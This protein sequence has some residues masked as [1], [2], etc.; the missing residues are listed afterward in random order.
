M[1]P[2]ELV[3]N[4]ASLPQGDSRALA[5]SSTAI[6]LSIGSAFFNTDTYD[7]PSDVRRRDTGWQTVYAAVRMAVEALKES[8]DMLLPLKAV[9]GAMSVLMKN[10]DVGVSCP[11]TEHLIF[12]RFS[13]QQTLD[14]MNIMEEIEQRVHSLSGVLASPVGEDDYAEKGRRVELRRFVL[15]CTNTHCMDICQS[16]HFPLR[17][18]KGVIEKLESL[19]EEHMLVRFLRNVDNTKALTGFIQEL[20][21]AITDYQV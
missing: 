13:L 21:N 10:Y 9:V 12:N 11:L 4:L 17:K 14:N 16:V 3:Q 19:S 2:A 20:A 1:S 8:S 15:N 7:T 6:A 5:A 18:L